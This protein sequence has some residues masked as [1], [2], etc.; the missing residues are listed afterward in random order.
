MFYFSSDNWLGLHY[1][2]QISLT[3]D[4][5]YPYRAKLE[6]DNK[7]QYDEGEEVSYQ[8]TDF[9]APIRTRKCERGRWTGEVPRCGDFITNILM[10]DSKLED[11]TDP[12]RP[13]LKFEYLD[14]VINNRSWKYPNVFTSNRFKKARLRVNDTKKYKW[15]FRFTGPEM[16][17]FVRINF[18]FI[19]YT[20]LPQHLKDSFI[21][22]VTM[23]VSHDRQCQLTN[24]NG[25]K[26]RE[27]GLKIESDFICDTISEEAYKR[28]IE[29]P[30][31]YMVMKTQSS[32]DI[33]HELIAVFLGKSY[34]SEEEPLCGEPEIFISQYS[35]FNVQFRDYTIGCRNDKYLY[36]SVSNANLPETAIHSLKC[37]NDMKWS[38]SYPE[39]IPRKPC[40]LNNTYIGS[41]SNDTIITSLDGLYFFNDTQY[42]AIENTDINFGCKYPSSDV[43]VGKEKRI[44][45]KTGQWSGSDIYCYDPNKSSKF[46]VWILI[47]ILFV[48]L[49]LIIC[50]TGVLFYIYS[51]KLKSRITRQIA[52][53][54]RTD[55]ERY[56]PY[57]DIEFPPKQLYDTY[58]V[59]GE[60]GDGEVRYADPY[61]DPNNDYVVMPSNV[62]IQS[63]NDYWRLPVSEPTYLEMTN[64]SV[65]SSPCTTKTHKNSD[66]QIYTYEL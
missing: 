57:D 59:V 19:N 47:T 21:F 49:I 5:L 43:L 58:D 22:N 60:G 24:Q 45:L 1:F 23:F 64:S 31:D 52:N 35:R 10:K 29:N 51:K 14:M 25:D 16:K 9:V 50:L 39:C 54:T 56:D 61:Y 12:D 55:S 7:L 42:Y 8:C 18:N 15:S 63:S 53:Q 6:P 4:P 40:S 44:C 41:E 30:G 2:F 48:A 62:Q 37:I 46:S 27:N 66:Q 13:V 17:L 32:L 34:G 20:L 38:G 3:S 26:W 36:V 28:D 33:P 11:I 65:K